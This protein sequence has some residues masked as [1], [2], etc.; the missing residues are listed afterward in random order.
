MANFK[1]K[2]YQL[3]HLTFSNKF[4]IK[5]FIAEVLHKSGLKEIGR[6][7]ELFAVVYDLL[8][9]H[10]EFEEKKGV[11]IAS[12]LIKRNKYGPHNEFH[13]VRV[14]GSVIDFSYNH[15]IRGTP[16]SNRTKLHSAMRKAVSEQVRA[17]REFNRETSCHW[18][19]VDLASIDTP[20]HV[21]HYPRS[22]KD[23]ANVFIN[24]QTSTIP[25]SFD[26]CPETH[27]PIF[28]EDVGH[29][30]KLNWQKYHQREAGFV[31][32]CA[33]CNVKRK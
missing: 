8:Q 28:R 17:F 21:D 20:N 11:G 4:D 22:F 5:E 32:S 30:F 31:L 23:L 27:Q 6:N 12:F 16:M 10:S 1:T 29:A 3:G 19:K 9:W 18:C 24:R 15:C 26:D 7:H 2:R 33:R 14:D 25:Y 13:V